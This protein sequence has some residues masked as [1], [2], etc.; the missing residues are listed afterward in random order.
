MVTTGVAIHCLIAVTTLLIGADVAGSPGKTALPPWCDQCHAKEKP[1]LPFGIRGSA[2]SD[3]YEALGKY[4]NS[5]CEH[6][7]DYDSTAR[8][9]FTRCS[10]VSRY[11]TDNLAI[12]CV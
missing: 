5:S 4:N 10:F 2:S 8:W 6:N 1:S 12:R 11:E 7:K 9:A 3:F